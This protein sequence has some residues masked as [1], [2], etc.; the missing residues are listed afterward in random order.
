MRK[1][2]KQPEFDVNLGCSGYVYGLWLA[3]LMVSAVKCKRV[4]LLVIHIWVLDTSPLKVCVFSM[5]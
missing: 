4:I 2:R 5:F 3:P 1:V